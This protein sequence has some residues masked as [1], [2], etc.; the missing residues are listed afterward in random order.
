MRLVFWAGLPPQISAAGSVVV[1]GTLGSMFK[2][3]V[4]A[5]AFQGSELSEISSAALGRR[6]SS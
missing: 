3:N 1:S 5:S 2:S 6:A 4:Q